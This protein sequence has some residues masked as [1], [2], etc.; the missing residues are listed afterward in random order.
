M[1]AGVRGTRYSGAHHLAVREEGFRRSHAIRPTTSILRFITHRFSLPTL[2]G[3]AARDAALV[4]NG[5]K[6]MGDLTAAL[7]IRRVK[8]NAR[9]MRN[10]R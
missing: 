1:T 5:G 7:N 2:P 4:A 8:V 9:N 6:P 3:I 10:T